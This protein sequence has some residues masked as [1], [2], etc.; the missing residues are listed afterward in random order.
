MQQFCG[1]IGLIGATN[2]GKSTLL[3]C[4]MGELISITANKPQTT[5]QQV[6]AVKTINNYQYI[7]VD[8]PGVHQ[9]QAKAINKYMQATAYKAILELDML[10]WILVVDNWSKEDQLVLEYLKKQAT[11][12]QKKPLYIVINKLDI[13]DEE[14]G[15]EQA[16]VLESYKAFLITKLQETPLKVTSML[17][18]SAKTGQGTLLLEELLQA[19]MPEAPHYFGTFSGT[20]S[21]LAFRVQELI[22]A[23]LISELKKELPYAT[24]VMVDQLLIDTD[25]QKQISATIFVERASQ[26]AIILGKQGH[27]IAKI[28]QLARHAIEKL[29]GYKIYLSLWVKVRPWTNDQQQLRHL[30]YI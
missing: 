7:Y 24:S 8:T 27:Q 2:V 29:L 4:L 9:Y 19:T 3:N 18:I 22:R 16:D 14:Q 17:A 12:L 21:S 25:E 23:A 28:G 10:L 11:F 30:G 5:R 20:P 26:K 6:L 15:E 13:L 1:Y